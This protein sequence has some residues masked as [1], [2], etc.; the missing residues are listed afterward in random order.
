MTDEE[1]KKYTTSQ[2]NGAMF[3][4]VFVYGVLMFLVVSLQGEVKKL[5]AEI[6]LI[7]SSMTQKPK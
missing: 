6:S 2:I 3:L 7:Q 1:I 4:T 5:K